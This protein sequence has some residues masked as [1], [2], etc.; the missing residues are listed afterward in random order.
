MTNPPFRVTKNLLEMMS[1]TSRRVTV[2]K[3]ASVSVSTYSGRPTFSDLSRACPFLSND[4]FTGKIVIIFLP[5]IRK[6]SIS[7]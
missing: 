3:K 1:I 7:F 4:R 5:W 2:I 6:M